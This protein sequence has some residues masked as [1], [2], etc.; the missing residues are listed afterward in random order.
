MAKP[1]GPQV[2]NSTHIMDE[3]PK[4][5]AAKIIGLAFL[6]IAITVTVIIFAECLRNHYLESQAKQQ[7]EFQIEPNL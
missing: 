4:H 5:Q 1:I 2:S 7:P 6:I 3:N